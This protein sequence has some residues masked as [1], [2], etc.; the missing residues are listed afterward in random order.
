MVEDV[1]HGILGL[2]FA[3]DQDKSGG[4]GWASVVRT[5]RPCRPETRTSGSSGTWERFEYANISIAE[6]AYNR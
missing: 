5:P 2:N 6:Q 4:V 3:D 1:Q